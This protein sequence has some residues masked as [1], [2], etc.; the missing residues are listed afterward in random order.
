MVMLKTHGPRGFES[1]VIFPAGM[2]SYIWNF[3][4]MEHDRAPLHRALLALGKQLHSVSKAEWNG[5]PWS[6]MLTTFQ[7]SLA[8]SYENT[9]DSKACGP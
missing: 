1:T 7:L 3:V 9:F 5:V 2:T 4:D 6:S 8:K